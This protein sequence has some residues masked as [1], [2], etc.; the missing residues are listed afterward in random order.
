ML[1]FINFGDD[2]IMYPP[3]NYDIFY[4]YANS[5]TTYS[6]YITTD[7]YYSAGD[8]EALIAPAIYKFSH[9]V[10]IIGNCKTITYKEYKKML[11]LEETKR[12]IKIARKAN[13][14]F[15]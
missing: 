11:Q 1:R 5:A 12:K 7:E 4:N 15:K 8:M 13:R 2:T 14:V 9:I 6:V 10:E 3:G